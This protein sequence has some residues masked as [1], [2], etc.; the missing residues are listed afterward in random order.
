MSD[1]WPEPRGCP[2]TMRDGPCPAC[3]E[4]LR[5]ALQRPSELD[6]TLTRVG[7]IVE[8]KGAIRSQPCR[9][10]GRPPYSASLS[11]LIG[12]PAA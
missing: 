12:E 5:E 9:Y 3:L 6:L 4:Q 7:W 1:R 8:A 10:T 11:R 2:G